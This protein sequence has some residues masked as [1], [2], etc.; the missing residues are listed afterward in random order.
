[1]K[2]NSRLTRKLIGASVGG[3]LGMGMA[4]T[5]SAISV[6]GIFFDEG[7]HFEVASVYENLVTGIGDVLT[8]YGEVTQING[9]ADFCVSGALQCEL[10]YVFGGFEVVAFTATEIVFSGGW[11]NFY[12]GET[13]AGTNNFNPFTSG[14]QAED[15]AEASDGSLWL[16]LEGHTNQVLTNNFG[17]VLGTLFSTGDQFGT[18][19][20]VGEGAGLLDVDHTGAANGNTAGAGA[21]ANAV[22]DTDSLSDNLGGTADFTLTTSFGTATVPPHGETPLAGS[23]DLRGRAAAPEPGT[24]AL[25][26]LGLLGL[27]ATQLRRRKTKK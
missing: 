5:A 7:A 9:T 3:L 10:T 21:A 1:M 26:G 13:S 27:G 16:T 15:I 23:A 17:L 22:F 14:S 8:G 24:I 6:G 19:N 25:L 18:G 12:V 20:D 2:K 11:V 4:T